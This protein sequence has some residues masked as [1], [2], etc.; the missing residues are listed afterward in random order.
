MHQP[1]TLKP[2]SD[3]TPKEKAAF[4]MGVYS[5]QA[6]DYKAMVARTNLTIEQ[7]KI[8][9][10]KHKI[11]T[12]VYPLIEKYTGYVDAGGLPTPEVEASII[13][14]INQ[15]TSTALGQIE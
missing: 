15:L 4:F 10:A 9:N 8:L 11:L 7:K 14:L 1:G 13:D 3:M 6:E 12:Q 2:V 5:S